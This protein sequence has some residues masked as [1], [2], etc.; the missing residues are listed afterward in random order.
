MQHAQRLTLEER[1]EPTDLREITKQTKF[2][3]KLNHFNYLDFINWVKKRSSP[4]AKR[5]Q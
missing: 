5:P 2:T 1:R 3:D 4:E